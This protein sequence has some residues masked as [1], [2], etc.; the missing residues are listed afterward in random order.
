[1]GFKR[2]EVIGVNVRFIGSRGAGD[3]Q[4]KM[5]HHLILSMKGG[6]RYQGVSAAD[7]AM[8]VCGPNCLLGSKWVDVLRIPP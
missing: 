6:G 5:S 3:F 7:K 2:S 8:V 4:K 1:M